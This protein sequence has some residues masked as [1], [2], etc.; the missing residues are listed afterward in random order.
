MK[1]KIQVFKSF[2]R[3]TLLYGIENCDINE[4]TVRE[5]RRIEGNFIKT[6]V[7]LPNRCHT[8][9][10]LK[11]LSISETKQAMT[12]MKLSFFKRLLQNNFTLSIINNLVE[13][14]IGAFELE[15]RKTLELNSS[16]KL[17][18][19]ILETD[20]ELGKISRAKIESKDV[21]KMDERIKRIRNLCSDGSD[22]AKNELFELV[23]FIN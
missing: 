9:D 14:N 11:A 2:V 8:S 19:M 23:K 1:A 5:L 12:Q 21:T 6:I 15:I 20:M 22:A 10:L 4:S 13:L 3:P 17:S 7:G 18:E 16:C